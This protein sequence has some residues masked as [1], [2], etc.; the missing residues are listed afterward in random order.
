MRTSV[1]TQLMVFGYSSLHGLRERDTGRPLASLDKMLR[2]D[3]L[4]SGGWGRI[5]IGKFPEITDHPEISP[6]IER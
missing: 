6:V 2:T 3:S 4:P 1:V 5:Y